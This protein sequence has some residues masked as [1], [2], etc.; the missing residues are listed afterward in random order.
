MGYCC[1]G[2]IAEVPALN[3]VGSAVSGL[4]FIESWIEPLSK[5]LNSLDTSA[6]FN[7]INHS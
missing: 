5:V 4:K 6:F 7:K 1:V 3:R 2:S